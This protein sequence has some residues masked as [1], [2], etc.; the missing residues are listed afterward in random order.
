MGLKHGIKIRKT[1]KMFK[2]HKIWQVQLLFLLNQNLQL[3]NWLE[4][5]KDEL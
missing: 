3:S 5:E 2:G 4:F 1:A